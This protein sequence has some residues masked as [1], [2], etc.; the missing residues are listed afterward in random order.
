VNPI[1]TGESRISTFD[2]ILAITGLVLGIAS[3]LHTFL[4]GYR[5][6][7][8][9]APV[10]APPP[11]PGSDDWT[12]LCDRATRVI[13]E[14]LAQFPAAIQ[15]EARAVA[16]V[17]K[18]RGEV[19]KEGYRVMGLYHNFTPGRTS[20]HKGPIILFLKT[21]EEVCLEKNLHFEEEVRFTY[22]H[23][24]GHHFGWDEVDLVRHGLPSGR[25]P[26]K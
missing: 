11:L 6:K 18:E 8:P 25:P 5:A 9:K 15:S 19:D 22:L 13:E 10:P 12:A 17:F 24:I 21:I 14:T 23:E 7:L 3:G 4:K 2:G 1:V 26:G 16:F 20:S